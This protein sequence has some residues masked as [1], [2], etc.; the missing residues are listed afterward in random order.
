MINERK[1]LVREVVTDLIGLYPR[2]VDYCERRIDHRTIKAEVESFLAKHFVV[3]RIRVRRQGHKKVKMP[4]NFSTVNKKKKTPHQEDWSTSEPKIEVEY[5]KLKSQNKLA[6]DNHPLLIRYSDFDFF[7][8]LVKGIKECIRCDLYNPL[9]IVQQTKRVSKFSSGVCHDYFSFYVE[10]ACKNS[11]QT[12]TCKISSHVYSM[13]IDKQPFKTGIK[14]D[15]VDDFTLQKWNNFGEFAASA[16]ANFCI[17]YNGFSKIKLCKQCGRI[18][19]RPKSGNIRGVFCSAECSDKYNDTDLRRKIEKCQIKQ[20]QLLQRR[21]DYL[22]LSHNS[23][24]SKYKNMM[25]FCAE[26]DDVGIKGGACPV[27]FLD[28]DVVEIVEKFKKVKAERKKAKKAAN[29]YDVPYY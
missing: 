23:I 7:I 2:V 22:S 3:K 13:L 26:C 12:S 28:A 1:R 25:S 9:G 16:F 6:Y 19:L 14:W 18:T 20:K 29:V 17:L 21:L 4:D 5:E 24:L 27:I 15:Y 11:K 8:R 10:D